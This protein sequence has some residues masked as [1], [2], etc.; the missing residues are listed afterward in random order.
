MNVVDALKG[1]S[2]AQENL[3][4]SLDDAVTKM[5]EGGYD[6]L[7]FRDNV[8]VVFGK[9]SDRFVELKAQGDSL[10]TT[11]ARIETKVDKILEGTSHAPPFS[12]VRQILLYVIKNRSPTTTLRTLRTAPMCVTFNV[13]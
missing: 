12:L 6:T 3:K 9:I 1:N 10:A 5:L 8:K 7:T 11:C 4:E 2:G 13:T